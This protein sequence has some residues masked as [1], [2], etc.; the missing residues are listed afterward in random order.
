MDDSANKENPRAV[1]KQKIVHDLQQNPSNPA[2]WL[3][4]ISHELALAG[5]D[6]KKCLN[7][8]KIFENARQS[9]TKDFFH[10]NEYVALCMGNAR[11][12]MYVQLYSHTT[13]SL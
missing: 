6:V 11:W 1:T 13:C 5:G 8:N 7:L 12:F 2:S 4:L 10:T 3:Q 9:V